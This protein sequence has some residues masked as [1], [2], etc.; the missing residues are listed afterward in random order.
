MMKKVFLGWMLL[1]IANFTLA[2]ESKPT[3]AEVKTL[4]KKVADR[5]IE[6][7]EESGKD[8]ALSG[9]RMAAVRKSGKYPTKYN[10]LTWHMGALYAGM[11]KWRT[12]A[13]D[14]AKYTAWLKM[15]GERNGWKL[16]KRPYHADD[17][18]VGQFYLSLYQEFQD[19][20]MLTPTQ[21]R[22]DWILAHPKTGSLTWGKKSDCHDRWGWCDSLFMAPPVWARLAKIT[23]DPKYL[24]F[25][26]QE[27]HATYDLL[28]DKEDHLFWRDSSFF[29][30]REKNG[31]KIYWA[32]GNGW[33]FGGLALMIPDLPKDWDGRSFYIDLYK[34]MA[35]SLK[36]CQRKDGTWS[37]GLL[38]GVEEY[39]IK[40][41]SG[42][43]F[44]TF[45][46][47]WGINNGLLDRATYEPVIFKAWNA[48]T[49]CVTDEGLLGYVQ[50]VGAAPGDSYADKTEVYGIGAFLA[51]GTEVYKLVGGTVP[52]T[53]PKKSK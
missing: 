36:N 7:F 31:S 16:H 50:P 24:D 11:D 51:A 41:T 4:T 21:E 26:D 43:S 10:D 9:K 23:G 5:Q 38:G 42:T 19:P 2:A 33:V 47:A 12:V 53:Q 44:Y 25:M 40:E 18:T 32:R 29:Q 49:E 8:R 30:K 34:Q 52:A 1:S 15:V 22:F 17:H 48:L 37:M 13:D 3:P 45:G 39:P 27:Y 46:L 20:A 35:E 14:P 6:T 28:W